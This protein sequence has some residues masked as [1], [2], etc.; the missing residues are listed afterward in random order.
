LP[1]IFQGDG[2]DVRLL[3]TNSFKEAESGILDATGKPIYEV[4]PDLCCKLLKVD[5]TIAAVEYLDAWFTGLRNTEGRTRKDYMEIEEDRSGP[6]LVKLN[7][8]LTFTELD[9]WRYLAM[10]EIPVN[11]LYKQGYRSLGCAP[12][13]KIVGDDKDERDGRWQDTSKCGGE[14]GIH[15]MKL[16]NVGGDGI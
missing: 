9:I 13:S 4:D 1:E 12:C 16:K 10:N 8:I 7:P 14:C 6:G 15:T 2:L 5:P 3:P 11:P